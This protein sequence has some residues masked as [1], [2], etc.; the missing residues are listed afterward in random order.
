MQT[1]FG[2]GSVRRLAAFIASPLAVAGGG[3]AVA[4]GIAAIP[5]G[6]RPIVRGRLA[7]GARDLGLILFERVADRGEDV[8]L[9]SDAVTALGRAISGVGVPIGLVAVIGSG[10]GR[11]RIDR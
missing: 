4:P 11:E 5:G 1:D 6:S 3:P 8:A 10:H 2:R 9:P 7:P